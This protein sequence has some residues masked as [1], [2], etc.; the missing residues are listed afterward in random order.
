M[1]PPNNKVDGSMNVDT[2]CQFL[3]KTSTRRFSDSES[4]A[5]TLCSQFHIYAFL[6]GLFCASNNFA[7]GRGNSQR[8]FSAEV[9]LD[10][11]SATS[12]K[13]SSDIDSIL[14]FAVHWSSPE[15]LKTFHFRMLRR[16]L[17]LPA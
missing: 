12:I 14:G 4:S 2:A 9:N 3:L 5:R 7:N 1:T 11:I 8:L 10:E 16:L 13:S 17:L 15:S 6:D